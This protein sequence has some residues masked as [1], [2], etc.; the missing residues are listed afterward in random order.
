MS[1][2]LRIH[3]YNNSFT[4]ISGIILNVFLIV[5][6]QRT[7]E[8]EIKKYNRIFFQAAAI[9]LWF[10]F[11]HLFEK[12]VRFLT[13]INFVNHFQIIVCHNGMTSMLSNPL[14]PVDQL[15]S[16]LFVAVTLSSLVSS[17]G[18]T[19]I[20]FYFRYRILCLN[21]EFSVIHQ[22]IS[23]IIIATSSLSIFSIYCYSYFN[24]T[25]DTFKPAEELIPYFGN[26]EGKVN[27]AMVLN[28]VSA[29]IAF[30]I[31]TIYSLNITI[32][33]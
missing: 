12:P 8:S 33:C 4:C 31:I 17:I 32:S 26:D 21:K 16:F 9:D 25:N 1:I 29:P 14:L 24:T 13:T 23:L 6:I 20:L 3:I 18:G 2:A 22:L 11:V 27:V 30:K 7:R 28:L 5:V 10:N 19:S 15:W